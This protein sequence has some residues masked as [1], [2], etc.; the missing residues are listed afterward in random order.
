M[1][2]LVGGTSFVP[3]ED[4][5]LV[6][7]PQEDFLTIELDAAHAAPLSELLSG[8]GPDAA[9]L[10]EVLGREGVLAAP[11]PPRPEGDVVVCGEGPLFQV[12]PA[13][14]ADVGLPVR[15]LPL[16]APPAV[17][18]LEALT[19]VAVL[20]VV[21]SRL[22]D[23]RLREVDEHCRARR[24]P[25]HLGFAEG[26][27]WYTGP[28][29]TGPG[30]PSYRDLRLRRLAASPWPQELAA[31]WSWLDAGGLP[32][33]DPAAPIGACTAAALITADLRAFLHGETPNGVGAHMGADPAT[34]EVR[35][36][37]VMAV[38]GDLLM[39]KAP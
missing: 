34:G 4:G 12:L 2:A 24:L 21:A 3:T 7:T 6:H 38:P 5:W 25:W 33:P 17:G 1:H 27:R 11:A 30:T 31:Y 19:G 18:E 8:D 35:R 22:L 32:Q 14:L 39:L 16:A 13:L 26:R 28:F 29:H 20:V 37:T 10:L 36:H 15:S 9:E 23:A